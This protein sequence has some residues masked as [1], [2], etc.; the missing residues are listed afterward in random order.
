MLVAGEGV[1][2]T[3]WMAEGGAL[4]CPS[5][6][7]LRVLPPTLALWMPRRELHEVELLGSGRLHRIDLELTRDPA[8]G[9]A[10]P[11][12]VAPARPLLTALAE[13]MGERG[14]DA[15][16][17]SSAEPAVRQEL[18]RALIREEFEGTPA[19]AIGVALPRTEWLRRAAELATNGAAGSGGLQSLA[20]TV[21]AH[22]RSLARALRREVGQSYG[23][24][25]AQVRL[26]RMVELW[27]EGLSLGESATVLG[28]AGPSAL[29]FMVRQVV[30]MTPS[31]LLGIGARAALPRERRRLTL[32]PEPRVDEVEVSRSAL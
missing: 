5:P 21:G 3:L 8:E 7:S 10:L 18:T 11:G 32:A 9:G 26:A 30:G 12:R 13:S 19:L 15:S 28:Y 14:D 25:R 1:A 23:D 24:W 29:S 31:Q 17:A 2:G 22:P 16:G 6:R 27:A 4:R 20:D